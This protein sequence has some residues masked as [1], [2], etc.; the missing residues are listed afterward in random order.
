MKHLLFAFFMMACNMQSH[1]QI[2]PTPKNGLEN[3][4]KDLSNKTFYPF[5]YYENE[6]F[7]MQIMVDS[8]S[9]GKLTELNPYNAKV[10][11]ELKLFVEQTEWVA[12]SVDGKISSQM[13]LISIK[14]DKD[15]IKDMQKAYPKEGLIEFQKSFVQYI[16]TT[17][18]RNFK[19]S[20]YKVEFE[21]DEKGRISILNITP[22]DQPFQ[23]E[24][25]RF[26]ERKT[27]LWNPAINNGKP[28]KSTFTLPIKMQY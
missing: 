15:Y 7:L 27:E 2:T 14:L 5:S 6:G 17:Y 4:T 8:L 19:Y 28:V 12:G 13:V 9:K 1:A 24:V 25:K 3:F 22:A 26:L 20:Q 23:F 21:V 11:K 10:F 18:Y 16:G